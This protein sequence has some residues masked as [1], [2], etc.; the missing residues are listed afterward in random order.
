MVSWFR[1]NN[2]NDNQEN[3]S[4]A[5][6]Q[7]PLP[8]DD[9]DEVATERTR[10]LSQ[11]IEAEVQPSPYNLVVVRSLRNISTNRPGF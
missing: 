9:H 1:K 2:T 10:L 6:H 7:G 3:E 4:S 8:P 5:S 11:S